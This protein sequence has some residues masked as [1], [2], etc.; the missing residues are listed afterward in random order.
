MAGTFLRVALR[1][2]DR[3]DPMT[4]L[5]SSADT[6]ASPTFSFVARANAVRSFGISSGPASFTESTSVS[7]CDSLSLALARTPA[8]RLRSATELVGETSERRNSNRPPSDAIESPGNAANALSR[9]SLARVVS[10]AK[11]NSG[12]AT[13]AWFFLTL[14]NALAAESASR[15]FA[16]HVDSNPTRTA[17]P[18][19][20]GIW[21]RRLRAI[22]LK[23]VAFEAD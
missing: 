4:L 8:A 20:D 15:W 16:S 2:A 22:A 18:H 19:D 13:S 17:S 21:L 9:N 11:A 1:A 6:S 3:S 10:R 7:S 12:L 14:A 5:F 23:A